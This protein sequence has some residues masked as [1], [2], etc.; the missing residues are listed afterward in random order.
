M[1]ALKI[2]IAIITFITLA[3]VG[4][5]LFVYLKCFGRVNNVKDFSDVEQIK[6]AGLGKFAEEIR[7]SHVKL[8]G[9]PHEDIYVTSYDGLRLYAGLY[10]PQNAKGTIV[11]IHGWRSYG[12]NDF[13]GIVERYMA[14]G[15]NVLIPCQRANTHSEGKYICMGAK[16]KY[17]C[18]AWLEYLYNRFGEDHSL[19]LDG[20][21][22]GATTVLMAS[23]L[24]LPKT[25]KGIIAD[26]GYTSAKD[27]AMSVAKNNKIYPYPLVW[28][29]Q[30][31]FWLLGGCSMTKE[32]TIDAVKRNR[33]PILFI[34]GESD[35]FVP[36]EMTRRA[37]DAAICEKYIFTVPEAGHGQSYLYKPEECY[38][39]L[40]DFFEKYD[41]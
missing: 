26:S 30:M 10:F 19:F 14:L 8:R 22:M 31:W 24:E 34:H 40:V 2:A 38:K 7:S 18:K 29:V 33:L 23:G 3:N 20:I 37:Y 6:Q 1:L 13:S 5:S 27:I 36:C 25:L 41:K 17:D 32:N 35:D 12:L 28:F 39:L 4:I 16:E 15:Y 21:S 9:L 11:L